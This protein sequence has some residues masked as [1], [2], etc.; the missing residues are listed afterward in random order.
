[1]K[2][3]ILP[4]IVF[5][6][7]SC[8]DCPFRNTEYHICTIHED[9]SVIDVNDGEVAKFCPLIYVNYMIKKI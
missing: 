8:D 3:N 4:T 2:E 7:K 5:K 1:M 6:V 9:S